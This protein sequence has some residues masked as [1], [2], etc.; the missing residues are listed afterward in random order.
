MAMP[1]PTIEAHQRHMIADGGGS[2][3]VRRAVGVHEVTGFPIGHVA[4]EICEK[5]GYIRAE[6]EHEHN[7][8]LDKDGNQCS[9][10]DYEGGVK[11]ICILCGGDGT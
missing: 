10:P 6:C 9:P 11:L 8:W 1:F 5:C 2:F 3:K 4:L 7:V